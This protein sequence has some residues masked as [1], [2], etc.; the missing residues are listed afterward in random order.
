VEEQP[1]EEELWILYFS[2]A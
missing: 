2:A 1:V